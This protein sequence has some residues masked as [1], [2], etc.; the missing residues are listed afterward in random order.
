AY[1]SLETR[2]SLIE[3]WIFERLKEEIGK[4]AFVNPFSDYDRIQELKEKKEHRLQ[5]G[6]GESRWGGFEIDAP[7]RNVSAYLE[8]TSQRNVRYMS[9]TGLRQMVAFR[10][11]ILPRLSRCCANQDR[12]PDHAF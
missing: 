6:L 11:R 10:W 12:C 2:Q 5:K 3:V 4:P 7:V 9:S 8:A 1:D